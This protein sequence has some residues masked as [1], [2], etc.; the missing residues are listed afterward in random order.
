MK[1]TSKSDLMECL[2]RDW[3]DDEGA[4]YE[5]TIYNR[6]SYSELAAG[7]SA[8]G[9]REARETSVLIGD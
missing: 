9:L 8:A 7:Y 3:G 6:A 5:G 1:G 4:T 2:A